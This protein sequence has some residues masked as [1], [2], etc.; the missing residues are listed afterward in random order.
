MGMMGMMGGEQK[1]QA[2]RRHLF[3]TRGT[4]SEQTTDLD[5]TANLIVLTSWT[6]THWMCHCL[7]FF[8]GGESNLSTN[9]ARELDGSYMFIL[10]ISRSV[11]GFPKYPGSGGLNIITVAVGRMDTDH[12]WRLEENGGNFWKLDGKTRKTM[13]FTTQNLG[14]RQHMFPKTQYGDLGNSRNGQL[15]G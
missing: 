5:Q 10:N 8:H 1:S 15:A 7:S 14:G 13:G 11:G 3:A 2:L 4:L 6:N 9:I 12:T